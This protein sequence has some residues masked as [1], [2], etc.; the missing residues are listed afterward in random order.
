MARRRFS[1]SR[2]KRLRANIRGKAATIGKAIKVKG[3]TRADGTKV[4]P[5]YRKVT[6][7]RAVRDELAKKRMQSKGYKKGYEQTLKTSK[8]SD[9][10]DIAKAKADITAAQR[11]RNPI[12]RKG[13]GEKGI[14]DKKAKSLVETHKQPK[15]LDQINKKRLDAGLEPLKTNKEIVAE[16]NDQIRTGKVQV[17]KKPTKTGAGLV[18][19]TLSGRLP[20]AERDLKLGK[21]IGSTGIA[22]PDKTFKNKQAAIADL[23][24]RGKYYKDKTVELPDGR[25]V[26][27][28]IVN[29]KAIER[30]TPLADGSGRV[31]HLPPGKTYAPRLQNIAPGQ[32]LKDSTPGAN[33]LI[34]A[35]KVKREAY[36]FDESTYSEKLSARLK[37][38]NAKAKNTNKD[39]KAAKSQE[40]AEAAKYVKES[41]LEAELVSNRVRRRKLT[42]K[43]SD[44]NTKQASR[45][46]AIQEV[47]EID[48][49]TPGA[50][51][52]DALSGQQLATKYG[53]KVKSPQRKLDEFTLEPPVVPTG[54]KPTKMKRLEGAPIKQQ[55]E[56]QSAFGKNRNEFDIK[57]W[58]DYNNGK[59]S[60]T[61][62]FLKGE[63][64]GLYLKGA[65][66]LIANRKYE[67]NL[68]KYNN[69]KAVHNLDKRVENL[70]LKGGN[71]YGMSKTDAIGHAK[72][73]MDKPTKRI[74]KAHKTIK[75]AHETATAAELES[76]ELLG[77]MATGRAK[78]VKAGGRVGIERSTSSLKTGFSPAAEKKAASAIKHFKSLKT[79]TKDGFVIKDGVKPKTFTKPNGKKVEVPEVIDRTFKIQKV[80]NEAQVVPYYKSK[81]YRR[82]E[83]ESGEVL[84]ALREGAVKNTLTR[85][86]ENILLRDNARYGSKIAANPQRARA[87]DKLPRRTNVQDQIFKDKNGNLRVQTYKRITADEA[88]KNPDAFVW[89]RKGT[90]KDPKGGRAVFG[91][92]SVYM[93]PKNGHG[94]LLTKNVV[95][96]KKLITPNNGK[97]R[98]AAGDNGVK[99]IGKQYWEVER[100]QHTQV[101]P[102]FTTKTDST[103]RVIGL[104][105]R[106]IADPTKYHYADLEFFGGKWYVKDGAKQKGK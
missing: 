20:G 76:Q 29:E 57:V 4:P 49:F 34:N 11:E 97:K 62:Q 12:P 91:Y 103:G 18:K 95:K 14:S 43:I 58:R 7:R 3:Y 53:T 2:L 26:T 28:K 79:R 10:K 94:S 25:V 19:A 86:Q 64:K 8:L 35:K 70:Y 54:Y 73:L 60:K 72:W 36:L 80:R 75:T 87:L 99:K 32:A 27:R 83:S 13:I 106:E 1:S 68:S 6:R 44:K 74:K 84:Y 45:E 98:L 67:L 23:K 101:S 61:G 50:K 55:L 16:L 81:D 47:H 48:T 104:S 82:I 46:K 52:S 56:A 69:K 77:L 41:A 65:K 59:I 66:Q 40:K 63:N 105:Q 92:P 93:A 31:F 24:K 39:I 17:F 5:H 102:G 30:I 9:P 38:R 96:K 78:V 100:I 21:T 42:K 89:T 90:I 71:L 51:R 33:L 88:L 15:N 85:S 37:T 22:V